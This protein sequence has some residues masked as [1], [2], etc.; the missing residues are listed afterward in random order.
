[1]VGEGAAL[2]GGVNRRLA[3]VRDP[4]GRRVMQRAQMSKGGADRG[5]G[6]GC[7]MTLPLS[8]HKKSLPWFTQALSANLF[9]EQITGVADTCSY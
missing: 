1:M 3:L 8:S 9:G 5:C 2:G 4:R 6:L 7:D